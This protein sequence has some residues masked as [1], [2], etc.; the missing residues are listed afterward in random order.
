MVALIALLLLAS[1]VAS[2]VISTVTGMLPGTAVW[3]HVA[4]WLASIAIITLLFMLIFK[5]LPEAEIAWGDVWLGGLVTALLFTVGKF[6]LGMYLGRTAVASSYGVAGSLVVLLL[7]VYYSS[8]LLLLGAEWTRIY[9]QTRGSGI[10]PAP[11]GEPVTAEI[12]A[13]EG[14]PPRS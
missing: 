4:N 6:L 3:A 5:Y 11:T 10:K 8:L 13:Q 1:L 12:Q 14:I 2:T 7:W 9:A